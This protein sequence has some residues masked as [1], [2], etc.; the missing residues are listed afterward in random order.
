MKFESSVWQN[1]LGA[2]C[3]LA[4]LFGKNVRDCLKVNTSRPKNLTPL[5]ASPQNEGERYSTNM[6]IMDIIY[7][8]LQTLKNS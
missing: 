3:R 8:C 2:Q 1:N 7:F 6:K 4:N 5:W